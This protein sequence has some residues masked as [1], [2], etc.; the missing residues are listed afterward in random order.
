MWLFP[1]ELIDWSRDISWEIASFF[2]RG[3]VRISC[4]WTVA[5]LPRLC[6]RSDVGHHH[7]ES[8]GAVVSVADCS[9][10]I[11]SLMNWD[12]LCGRKSYTAAYFSITAWFLASWFTPAL[13]Q[14]RIYSTRLP[15]RSLFSDL[16]SPIVSMERDWIVCGI[17]A[18][19]RSISLWFGDPHILNTHV[20]IYR[21]NVWQCCSE[22]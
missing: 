11:S 7:A 17:Q 10:T 18:E 21:T 5:H 22:C 8:A 9:P 1:L 16:G 2:S 12:T 13:S 6:H 14:N 15:E 20:Q 19:T 3:Q 4:I